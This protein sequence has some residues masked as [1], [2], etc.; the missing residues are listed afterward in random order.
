MENNY[1]IIGFD[2]PTLICFL[3]LFILYNSFKIKHITLLKY[4]IFKILH[5]C[6]VPGIQH[7]DSVFL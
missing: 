7:S 4:K 5:F 2:I 6:Q 3:Y 1:H